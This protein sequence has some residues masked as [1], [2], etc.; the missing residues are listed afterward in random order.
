MNDY[1]NKFIT[2]IVIGQKIIDF[3]SGKKIDIESGIEY[4]LNHL[5]FFN[6]KA[7]GNLLKNLGFELLEITDDGVLFLIFLS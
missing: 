3:L 7:V 1:I 2:N 4:F 6:P 5:N